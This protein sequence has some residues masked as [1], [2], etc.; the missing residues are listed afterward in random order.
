MTEDNF[1][2][3]SK[4]KIHSMPS[5]AVRTQGDVHL[6]DENEHGRTPE[7]S[8][9]KD[10]IN[11]LSKAMNAEVDGVDSG[12]IRM[13]G[14][15]K[16]G[17]T[18][19]PVKCNDN[20]DAVCCKTC[21]STQECEEDIDNPGD[22][23]CKCCWEEYAIVLSQQQQVRE[24]GRV[25]GKD[26]ICSNVASDQSLHIESET[27]HSLT[28]QTQSEYQI[29]SSQ[30]LHTQT[31]TPLDDQRSQSPRKMDSQQELRGERNDSTPAT[32]HVLLSSRNDACSAKETSNKNVL[33][34]DRD[35][36]THVDTSK[37]NLDAYERDDSQDKE[38]S[39]IRAAVENAVNPDETT[40]FS[41][42]D[43]VE[44]E[45]VD[46]ETGSIGELNDGGLKNEKAEAIVNVKNGSS[47]NE[48]DEMPGI[49]VVG[50]AHTGSDNIK[51]GHEIEAIPPDTVPV[52]DE[53]KDKNTND[54]NEEC[55]NYSGRDPNIVKEDIL[56]VI[57]EPVDKG[58]EIKTAACDEDNDHDNND[59]QDDQDL[60]LG[61]QEM[62]DPFKV[63]GLLTQAGSLSG[64]DDNNTDAM[65]E[66]VKE[67]DEDVIACH[68]TVEHGGAPDSANNLGDTKDHR[69][70]TIETSKQVVISALTSPSQNPCLSIRQSIEDEDQVALKVIPSTKEATTNRVDCPDSPIDGET[71]DIY[72][73]ETQ[74]L[75]S[76]T[77]QPSA[78][79]IQEASIAQP[80]QIDLNDKLVYEDAGNRVSVRSC[81]GTG[82]EAEDVTGHVH[83]HPS[84]D[85]IEGYDEMKLTPEKGLLSSV[86]YPKDHLE[87]KPEVNA[88][89]TS[90]DVN[91]HLSCDDHPGSQHKL[92]QDLLEEPST[93]G[94]VIEEL[95]GIVASKPPTS[96]VSHLSGRR[97][98]GEQHATEW[99]SSRD[100]IRSPRL[101]L[102][103]LK[104]DK[105]KESDKSRFAKDIAEK[106]SFDADESDDSSMFECHAHPHENDSLEDTQTQDKYLEKKTS[107]FKRLSRGTHLNS[108]RGEAPSP[109]SFS[110][111]ALNSSLGHKRGG[112][113]ESKSVI[114]PK[115][116]RYPKA[117]Y[118]HI[119]SHSEWE[120]DGGSCGEITKK[121][122]RE[123][124]SQTN[125]RAMKQLEEIKEFTKHLPS[126]EELNKLAD[127]KQLLDEIAQLNRSHFEEI[128]ELKVRV[129][130]FVTPNDLNS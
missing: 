75:P 70:P 80:Q 18:L 32:S 76:S 92:S 47:F 88:P 24:A 48:Y 125:H 41:E 13:D 25:N 124:Q 56:A 1:Q 71:Q 100:K 27:A 110:T 20:G 23:Y 2:T 37:C 51:Y 21:D 67:K 122:Y 65:N 117:N 19:E 31:L 22:Y 113:N 39:A 3:P 93:R 85:V 84:E 38:T 10:Q 97:K 50:D 66:D 87:N 62:V 6:P 33:L 106:D 116:L 40:C 82:H 128:T 54:K 55:Q 46:V 86:S 14:G 8:N 77:L 91:Y 129:S 12:T 49:D 94:K 99:L 42:N 11:E 4:P 120:D 69:L 16:S 52:V 96:R 127:R 45:I 126:A 130:S 90:D 57:E 98:D 5:P 43:F 101:I 79:E 103:P 44:P 114:T 63:N 53:S 29:E 105:D 111:R 89:I 61:T 15:P 102:P 7:E 9:A 78:N 115:V 123:E 74:I 95:Y 109:K 26:S 107:N 60:S 28:T 64:D 83:S 58:A 118:E 73:A 108:S 30:Q 72:G 112:H 104:T 121:R 34:A 119:E 17:T 68:S 36:L 59:E 81:K 35:V